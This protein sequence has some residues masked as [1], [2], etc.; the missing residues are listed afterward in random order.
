LIYGVSTHA[1]FGAGVACMAWGLYSGLQNGLGHLDGLLRWF[2]NGLLVLQFPLLHSL[3]LTSRGRSLLARLAPRAHGR[4]LGSTLFAAA[5]SVQLLL[6]FGLWSP[7][8]VVWWRPEG[9]PLYALQVAYGSGWLLLLKAMAD[10]GLGWTALWR[11]ESPR[12]GGL[13]TGGLFRFCRQPIY[14]AFALILWCTPVWSPDRLALTLVWSLY[15]VVG[16]LHKERRYLALFGAEFER[17]RARVPY[18]LPLWPRRRASPGRA[19]L[20]G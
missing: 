4:T 19:A 5:A 14:L 2:T 12:Y 1:L 16:P 8:G 6:T 15:C 9:A 13:P 10:A 11:G 17:Y 20:P 3:L 7:S 18:L